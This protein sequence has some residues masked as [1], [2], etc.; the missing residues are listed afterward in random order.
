MIESVQRS[1]VKLIELRIWHAQPE[2][3]FRFIEVVSATVS[4]EHFDMLLPIF[5]SNNSF[6]IVKVTN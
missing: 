1:F 6:P 5:L 4:G 2:D 3:D